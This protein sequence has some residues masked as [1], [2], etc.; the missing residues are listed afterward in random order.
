MTTYDL[1]PEP[2]IG[3]RLTDGDGDTWE[4]A[5][6]GWGAPS[7]RGTYTWA[8][9]LEER[10]P[11]TEV[12]APALPTEPGSII[13][14]TGV[15][16][17]EPFRDEVLLLDSVGYWHGDVGSGRVYTTRPGDRIDAFTVLATH[18]PTTQAVVP[19]KEWET[20]REEWKKDRA[21]ATVGVAHAL[22]AFLDAVDG[23]A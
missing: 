20:L 1:P 17:G 6:T 3:T 11:L 21:T 12:P 23:A 14:A 9:L 22:N 19:R 18:D 2:P 16:E 8:E 7:A 10:G 4:R 13:R 15:S 5:I